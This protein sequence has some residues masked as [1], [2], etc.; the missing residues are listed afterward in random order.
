MPNLD[1]TGPQ[2]QGAG[3]GRGLGNCGFGPGVR[4]GFG[5][6]MGMARRGFG[7]CLG[8]FWPQNKEEQKQALTD[9]RKSLEEELAEVKKEEA[10]LLK[11]E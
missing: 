6:G 1:G 11:N 7:R 9:Y 2:G 10:G 4:R 3:T 5:R 8:W